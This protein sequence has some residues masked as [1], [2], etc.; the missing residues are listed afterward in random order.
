MAQPPAT[1][2]FDKA[3]YASAKVL[4]AFVLFWDLLYPYFERVTAALRG[5]LTVSENLSGGWID[6]QVEATQ[7]YPIRGLGNPIPGGKTPHAVIVAMVRDPGDPGT[8]LS[9]SGVTP[10][11]TTDAAGG[12]VILGLSGLSSDTRYL[13]RLLVLAE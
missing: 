9:L 13:V 5:G 2:K 12:V 10:Q 7:S 8:V 4:E 11:W 1:P 6:V 3:K